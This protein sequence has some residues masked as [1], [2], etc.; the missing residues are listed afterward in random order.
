MCIRDSIKGALVT[1]D[2]MGCHS[3]IANMI[4]AQQ[5]HYLLA[6][7]KNQKGLYEEVHDWMVKHKEKMDSFSQTDYVGGRI[8]KRT[9][10]VT[11]NLTY[12][13]ELAAWQ[14]SK[15]IILVQGERTFKNGLTK[16]TF[17]QR[18]YVSSADEEAAYFGKATRNHWS[19]ENQLHWYL[20]VVFR[21]DNQRVRAGNA[22][23]NMATLRKMALQTLLKHK[24]KGSLKKTRKRAAWNEKFLFSILQNF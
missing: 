13:D 21:E 17:Q 3:H 4:R 8:E 23:E 20:D 1:I 11:N 19:I 9:T 2:A 18:F 22:P 24:G 5:G 16:N 14:D 7:K 10:F 6:L 12:I 15:T